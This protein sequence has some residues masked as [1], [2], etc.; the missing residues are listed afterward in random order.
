MIKI[1]IS[2]NIATRLKELATNF[3]INEST[4]Y[5]LAAR[6]YLLELESRIQQGDN[7]LL[8]ELT[9]ID[10]YLYNKRI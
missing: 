4:L 1:N 2:N 10:A 9:G 8:S 3:G 6:K 7:Q 5:E